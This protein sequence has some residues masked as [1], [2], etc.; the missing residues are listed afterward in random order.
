MYPDTITAELQ[1]LASEASDWFEQAT[2]PDGEKFYRLKDGHPEWVKEL[3]YDAHGDLLPDDWRY[4][5][6]LDALNFIDDAAEDSYTG[7]IASEFANSNV[8]VYTSDRFDWLSSNLQRQSYVDDAIQDF[9]GAGE[10]DGIV[11][12]VGWGQYKE[13]E[14]VFYSVATSLGAQLEDGDD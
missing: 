12:V 13:S 1:K 11:D 6:I 4:E 5:T 8:D 3:V 14:E 10:N 2:R 7:D 9:G